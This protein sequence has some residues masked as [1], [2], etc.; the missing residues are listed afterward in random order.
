MI[1]LFHANELAEGDVDLV[2]VG[3]KH[4][5]AEL[6]IREVVHEFPEFAHGSV[7]HDQD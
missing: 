4:Q 7:I 2:P 5:Q 6:C 3:H 1:W